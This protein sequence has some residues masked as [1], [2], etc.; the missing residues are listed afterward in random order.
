M[1][2]AAAAATTIVS[3]VSASAQTT[4]NLP[5]VTYGTV[6]A[7][8]YANAKQ[9]D[10][11]STRSSANPDYL[12]R[13][14]VKFD[15][16]NG[17]PSG[18]S[19]T[20]AILT[21]TIKTGGADAS[22]RI[23]VYQVTQSFGDADFTWNQRYVSQKTSWST[24]GGDLGSQLDVQTVNSTVGGKVTF[25]VTP[26]VKQ[27]VAGGLGSSRY[28]RLALADLDASTAD[29][30]RE[31]V[32]PKDP[33]AANRPVLTV[34][35]GGSSTITSTPTPPPPP[36]PASSGGTTL[37]VLQYNTHHGGWGTDGVWDVP[38]LMKSA[39]K[40]N[41]DIIS[42]NEVEYKDSWS[43]NG[44]DLALYLST[45][46]S[47]TGQTWYGKFV[48]GSGATS[49]IGNAIVSKIPFDTTAHDQLTGGR[50]VLNA[51]ITVNGRTINLF[52]T[53][54]DES[55][56]ST[57]LA[58]IGE[59]ETWTNGIAQ[60]RIICGDFNAQSTD[61]V[62]AK[63]KE[64]YYDAW[65][66]AQSDGTATSFP[67]NTGQTRNSRIDYC[68]ISHSASALQL[69]SAQVL[70]TRDANGVQPSDHRPLLVVFDVK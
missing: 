22:R 8:S 47:L 31:F 44:D 12:R 34:T 17:I 70:D 56:S 53:H 25:D 4:V 65:A 19:V 62:S 20:S 23:A 49:G 9:G 40:A 41:P 55:S 46:K 13:A 33:N 3:A 38:R 61:S 66:T 36:A 69:K 11:L 64:T 52:S 58:E 15:T 28:T 7:G 16:Q 21:L 24:A 32:T 45:L 5:A 2:C 14:I 1:L 60:Q 68:Y 59:M 39:L 29:S 43:K 27:A 10:L 18:A 30:Y 37:R 48:V 54:L 50:A 42:F 67:G 6:R 51:T 57:R 26:L 35:Y 63:M